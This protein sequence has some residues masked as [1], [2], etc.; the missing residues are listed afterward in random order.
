MRVLHV[1]SGLVIRSAGTRS[2]KTNLDH[3][4]RRLARMLAERAAALRVAG[5]NQ[6]RSAHYRIERGNP[7]RIYQLADGLLVEDRRS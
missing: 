1:P 6:R 3:A 7:V 2:Q 4:V 5:N